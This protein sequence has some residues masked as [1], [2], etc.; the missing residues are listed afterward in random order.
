[1]HVYVEGIVNREQVL[2]YPERRGEVHL[3]P[4]E[5]LARSHGVTVPVYAGDYH[6]ESTDGDILIGDCLLYV[7]EGR[8]VLKGHYKLL[9]SLLPPKLLADL[10]SKQPVNTSPK[11]HA[12][13]VDEYGFLGTDNYNMRE[14]DITYKSILMTHAPTRCEPPVCGVFTDSGFPSLQGNQYTSGYTSVST[15]NIPEVG[16]MSNVE[17][18]AQEGRKTDQPASP[19]SSDAAL[20]QKPQFRQLGTSVQQPEPKEGGAKAPRSPTTDRDPQ[21][22]TGDPR[23]DASGTD[24]GGGVNRINLYDDALKKRI[25]ER[26]TTID[27]EWLEGAHPELLFFL[28]DTRPEELQPSEPPPAPPGAATQE[29]SKRRKVGE[30]VWRSYKDRK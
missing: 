6:D 1:M 25:V 19:A 16:V 5:V 27:P 2:A 11:I 12:K 20:V 9:K 30:T 23:G 24:T 17:T 15:D 18:Q 13:F 26:H 14:T 29:A 10:L 3:R 7:P 8:Q 22:A 4:F 21:E 28:A